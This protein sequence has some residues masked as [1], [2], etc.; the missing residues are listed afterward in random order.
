MEALYRSAPDKKRAGPVLVGA[1]KFRGP[2]RDLGVRPP[3]VIGPEG[4]DEDRRDR[5]VEVFFERAP[6]RVVVLKGAGD[7][8]SVAAPWRRGQ[9]QGAGLGEVVKHRLPRLRGRV[10]RLVDD[11]QVKQ[12]RRWLLLRGVVHRADG[13][14]QGNHDVGRLQGAPI[15]APAGHFRHPGCPGRVR[16]DCQPAQLVLRLE[17][18][19]KLPP[20]LFLRCQ[21]QHP[22]WGDGHEEGRGH[23]DGGLPSPSGDAD[24]RRLAAGQAPVSQDGA[25]R[26]NLRTAPPAAAPRQQG[27]GL[28]CGRV[29]I[30]HRASYPA[31]RHSAAGIQGLSMTR[32][33]YCLPPGSPDCRAWKA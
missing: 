14:R 6:Q 8:L 22:A 27:H 5:V 2:G 9:E 1:Q 7:P 15:S 12:V 28:A 31:P 10:V 23:G 21:H 20:Q 18:P 25:Q 3:P 26:P 16:Q 29:E 30:R 17:V 33:A 24:Q 32:S 19:G 11:D 4:R 13:V